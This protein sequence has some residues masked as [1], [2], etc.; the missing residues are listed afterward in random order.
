MDDNQLKISP[1]VGGLATGLKSVHKRGKSLWIGW[2]GI[3]NEDIR[4]YVHSY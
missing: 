3:S 1:S 2:P 4:F